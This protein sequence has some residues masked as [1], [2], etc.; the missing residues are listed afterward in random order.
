M[1][2][3]ADLPTPLTFDREP[4]A[5]RGQTYIA[6]D[7]PPF[8]AQGWPLLTP[9]PLGWHEVTQQEAQRIAAQL[10]STAGLLRF[11][12]T[13][14][15]AASGA[16]A[17]S[18]TSGDGLRV[19]ARRP[20]RPP[21]EPRLPRSSRRPRAPRPA[22]AARSPRPPRAPRAPRATRPRRPAR[23]PRRRRARNYQTKQE[24]GICKG[25]GCTCWTPAGCAPPS[26]K[27]VFGDFTKTD[28]YKGPCFSY[29]QCASGKCLLDSLC[30][31]NRILQFWVRQFK[32][33]GAWIDTQLAKTPAPV[34]AALQQ[35]AAQPSVVLP[36]ALPA[37]A[38]SPRVDR[39]GCPPDR[40]W[41]ISS[42]GLVCAILEDPR[43][44][45]TDAQLAAFGIGPL[46]GGGGT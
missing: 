5:A 41:V 25:P 18:T 35:L 14:T 40:K 27:L 32:M 38:G 37:P 3:V 6:S 26:Y 30:E 15:T 28:C 1:P 24:P 44:E 10:P 12:E 46:A 13:P 7:A 20:P 21:R 33:V 4:T 8:R 23:P 36:P 39:Y 29:E 17:L 16:A 42:I 11:L 34:Q 31:V 22:R 43:P 9:I 19:A 2:L 45:A